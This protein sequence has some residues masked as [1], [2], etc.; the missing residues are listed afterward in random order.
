MVDSL[1][2]DGWSPVPHLYPTKN[3]GIRTQSKT[4]NKLDVISE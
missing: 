2:D 1:T 3:I 4:R